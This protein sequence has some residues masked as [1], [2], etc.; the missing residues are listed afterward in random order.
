MDEAMSSACWRWFLV[1]CV[2]I[3]G[4]GEPEY[5]GATRYPLSGKVT[6]DGEPIDLGSIAFLPTSGGDQRV[7][8]GEIIDGA[9]SVEEARGANAGKYRVQIRWQ[10]RTGKQVKD[11]WTDEMVDERAEGLPAKFHDSTELTAEV[12]PAQRTFDFHL[13]SN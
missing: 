13:K 8:G 5:S 12:S 4:C 6:Y 3:A 1:L 7:S 11:A 10:K 9:Y 2:A